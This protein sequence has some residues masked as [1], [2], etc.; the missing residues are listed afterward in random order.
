M[1]SSLVIG[2][3]VASACDCTVFATRAGEHV[4]YHWDVA[5]WAEEDERLCGGTVAAADQLVVAMSTHYGWPLAQEGPTIEYFWDRQLAPS[6]CSDTSQCVEGG[7]VVLSYQPFDTH[8]LAHTAQGGHGNL[9]FI[10]EGLASRWQ[11]G[12]VDFGPTYL[13]SATFLSEAQLRAQLEMRILQDIDQLDYQRGMTWLVALET[14]FGPA[15][16]GEFIDQLR[17]SSSPDDVERALQRVFGISLAESVALAEAVPEGTVDDPICEFANLPTWTLTEE[18]GHS[19]YVDRGEAHCDDDDL[20]SIQGQLA[21]WLFAIEFPESVIS[22]DV[23]VSLPAGVKRDRQLMTLATCN[24]KVD[25]ESMPF[26]VFSP[27]YGSETVLLHGRHV[28]ALIGEV[29]ADGSVELP[30]VSFEVVLPPIEEL[31]P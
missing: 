18:P 19:V 7:R 23:N 13:T 24:G 20:I 28:G 8:E 21:T 12:M 22:L 26:M 14:A 6:A 25:I 5:T 11:S 30:R 10:E 9:P 17:W 4:V 2:L 29:T 16:V 27:G 31:S 15:K 3:A 1:R